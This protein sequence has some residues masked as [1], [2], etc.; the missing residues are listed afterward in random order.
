MKLLLAAPTMGSY[1]GIEAVVLTLARSL[2]ATSDIE[3]RVVFK[4]A[5]GNSPAASLQAC[6]RESGVSVEFV[7]RASA[8]LWR[9]VGWADLVHGHNLSPDIGLFAALRRKP[10]VAT[11]HHRLPSERSL[12]VRLWQLALRQPC[13]TW[14]N[15]QSVAQTWGGV[16]PPRRR[17]LHPVCELAMDFAPLPP[18]RGFSFVSRW[19]ANKGAD[20]LI[21][22]YARADFDKSVHPLHMMGDG[23]LLA[24]WRAR[25]AERKIAGV[26]L[27]GFVGETEKRRRIA[28]SR[29]LVVP[30]H[31]NEDM[32]LTPL[33]GRSLG[34]PCIA[35][36][37]GG[38]AEVAGSGAILCE[39]GSVAGLQAALE[40][41]A[42]LP[43]AEY[44]RRS[45]AGFRELPEQVPTPASYAQRY[46]DLLKSA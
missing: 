12:R 11:V 46:R 6:A 30:P 32:G 36:R 41:A 22:A 7:Q 23:P 2:V 37:D 20:V 42:G 38:L 43:E 21:E 26:T 13:E 25:V 19:I 29:W 3:P 24:E 4:L 44:V 39:P 40:A 45:E 33:E 18:R 17:V 15:S 31:T 14:F 5:A 9:A 16:A 27:H 10:L 1:G 28:Q 34:V 8:Q 35:T